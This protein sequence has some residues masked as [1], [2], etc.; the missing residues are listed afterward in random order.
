M[1]PDEHVS[2]VDRVPRA[3]DARRPSATA[4]SG[5]LLATVVLW[6]GSWLSADE[7]ADQFTPLYDV[8]W[9]KW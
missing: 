6:R 7:V 1:H 2:H 5:F 4:L 9:N 3:G 8:L